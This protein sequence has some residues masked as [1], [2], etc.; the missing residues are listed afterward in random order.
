VISSAKNFV[1]ACALFFAFNLL[2]CGKPESYGSLAKTSLWWGFLFFLVF[3]PVFLV[4]FPLLML[5]L[6][7]AKKRTPLFLEPITY[8]FFPDHIE[9]QTAVTQSTVPWSHFSMIRETKRDFFLYFQKTGASL[10]PKHC[11]ANKL[12]VENFKELVRT[13][14]SGRVAFR[15]QN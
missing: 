6:L 5:A 11:F 12:D 13:N 14:F 4:I 15:A 9:M 3:T 2:F 1:Y 10:I 7:A 8:S